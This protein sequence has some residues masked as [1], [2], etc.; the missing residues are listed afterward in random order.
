TLAGEPGAGVDQGFLP[1]GALR[2]LAERRRNR[3]F[4]YRATV[5]TTGARYAPAPGYVELGDAIRP[6]AELGYGRFV[7]PAGHQLRGRVTS[8]RAWRNAAG[9][10]ESGATT[11]LLALE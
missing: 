2:L 7:S 4:W 6:G 3:G 1:R 10:F 8:S 9:S 5:A 11:G